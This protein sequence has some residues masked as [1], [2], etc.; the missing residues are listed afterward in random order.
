MPRKERT[1]TPTVE[2]DSGSADSAATANDYAAV[3]ALAYQL[4]LGRGGPIG[5]PEVDWFRAEEELKSR[6]DS[7]ADGLKSMA[8]VSG[9]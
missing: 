6:T 3:A 7:P 4:W 2:T 5:S 1:E 8:A 9:A